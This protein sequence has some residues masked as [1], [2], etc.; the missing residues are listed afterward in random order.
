MISFNLTALTRE[1][2]L[3]QR[4]AK[5]RTVFPRKTFQNFTLNSFIV[6]TFIQLSRFSLRISSRNTAL[7]Y[8]KKKAMAET[9]SQFNFNENQ[10]METQ[11]IFL[12]SDESEIDS[13]C[14]SPIP[15]LP[16]N[17]PDTYSAITQLIAAHHEQMSLS[18]T[19]APQYPITPPTSLIS[20][21]EDD[22]IL[23]P[24][25][26][27]PA[28]TLY[29]DRPPYSNSVMPANNTHSRYAGI[30]DP[31]KPWAIRQFSSRRYSQRTVPNY[32]KQ[33]PI[34]TTVSYGLQN[35]TLHP[36]P[37]RNEWVT[38]CMV[39]GKSYDKVIEE[40][41]ADYLNQTTQPG[42]TVRER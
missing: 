28:L 17:V 23:T 13:P 3:I 27:S 39:C 32:I 33:P 8:F 25:T 12:S 42:E 10:E 34:I 26:G 30:S 9:N 16:N 31:R 22:D 2:P 35:L 21:V 5:T 20:D 11:P 4:K 14:S 1:T 40:T 24:I 41:V 36:H 38:G 18:G 37:Q 7:K 29:N 15:Q 19:S 6:S